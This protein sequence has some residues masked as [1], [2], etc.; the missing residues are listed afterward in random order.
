MIEAMSNG[1]PVICLGAGGPDTAVANGGGIIVP[2]GSRAAVVAG[3][4]Q[5]LR[6]YDAD[7]DRL[8]KDGQVAR[9]S[10]ERHYDWEH[11]GRRMHEFYQA[12]VRE[13]Q[14]AGKTPEAIV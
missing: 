13:K 14:L 1:L 8:V 7:R 2:L 6:S 11:K 9:Q 10:V 4:A 3:L 12:T 5:A